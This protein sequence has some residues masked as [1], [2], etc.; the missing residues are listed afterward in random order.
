MKAAWYERPGPAREV[1]HVG[2][3]DD[4]EPEA[5]EVRIRVVMSGVHPG[6]APH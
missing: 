6:A 5:N 1:L 4:P 3:L 2:R